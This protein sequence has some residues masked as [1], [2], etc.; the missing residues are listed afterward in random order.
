M[1]KEIDT[2]K[3]QFEKGIV[4]F[5]Q[6]LIKYHHTS[7]PFLTSWYSID[8][9]IMPRYHRHGKNPIIRWRPSRWPSLLAIW[10]N[11][12]H[13]CVQLNTMRDLRKSMLHKPTLW[14]V[15]SEPKSS[16]GGEHQ[17]AFESLKEGLSSDTVLGYFDPAAEHKVHVDGCPLGISAILVQHETSDKSWQVVQ[18]V[19]RALPDAEWNYSQIELHMLVADLAWRKFHVFLYGLPFKIVTDHKPL[20]VILYNPGHK[21]C[22]ITSSRSRIGLERQIFQSNTS[23]HPLPRENCTK[24]ELGTTKDVKQW[25]NFV[26]PSDIPR[27]IRKEELVKAKDRFP[28]VL[29]P[30]TFR[31]LQPLTELKD[32]RKDAV[33][34]ILAIHLLRK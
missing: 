2:L 29:V 3:S 33:H 12:T 34:V 21:T 4:T 11:W 17:E 27:A 7:T 15:Y 10:R 26:I 31:S 5:W 20:E 30:F 32:S 23:S 19:S 14:G 13:S 18:Y 6:A 28:N 9:S 1:C 22:L 25:V 8:S 24:R 16:P